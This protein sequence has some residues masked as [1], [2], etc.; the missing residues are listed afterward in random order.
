MKN[1]V[2]YSVGCKPNCPLKGLLDEIFITGKQNLENIQDAMLQWG[3]NLD[4]TVRETEF[5]RGVSEYLDTYTR[6]P[7]N[8]KPGLYSYNFCLNTDPFTTQPSGAINMSV[9]S[10]IAWK[11]ELII[12]PGWDPS[13]NNIPVSITCDLCGNPIGANPPSTSTATN[14]WKNF[15]YAFNMHIMEE[16]YNMIVIENGVARLALAR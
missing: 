3:F 10:S 13:L 15:K 14:Y 1:F 6:S 9:F 4:E 2:E 5:P 16:R 12:P 7:G 11:Y 8:P